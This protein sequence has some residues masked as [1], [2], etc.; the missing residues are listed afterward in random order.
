MKTNY[1]FRVKYSFRKYEDGGRKTPVYQ[2]IRTDFWYHHNENTEGNLFMIWPMFEDSQ[3]DLVEPGIIIEDGIARMSI[4]NAGMVNYHRNKI[5]IGTK[6]YFMEGLR[7]I[8]DCE[9]IE[10]GTRLK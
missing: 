8:A 1:D 4:V 9:V 6:G 3:R 5:I 2:G 7:K 10:I